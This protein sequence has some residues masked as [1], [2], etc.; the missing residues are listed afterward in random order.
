MGAFLLSRRA[1]NQLALSLGRK[2]TVAMLDID[3]FKKFTK[4]NIC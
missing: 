2:Y 3:H 4:I 1:L